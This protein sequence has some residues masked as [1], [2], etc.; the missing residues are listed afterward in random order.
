MAQEV[1]H[2]Q[3]ELGLRWV[4]NQAKLFETQKNLLVQ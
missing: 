2:G 4:D 1:N 3:S